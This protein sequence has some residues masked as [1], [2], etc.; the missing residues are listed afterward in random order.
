MSHN[1]VFDRRFLTSATT[2]GLFLLVPASHGVAS[3]PSSAPGPAVGAQFD[4]AHVYVA[5]P[6][7]AAFV[8]SFVATF[9]GQASGAATTHVT[10]APS[11][12]T[13]VGVETP[14]GRL[15]VFAFSTPV[16]YPF[17]AEP[18]GYL[19]SDMDS[20]VAGA[21][22]AGADV[23][24]APFSDPIGRDAVIQWP[25]GVTMQ[26]YWH[27]VAPSAPPLATV[28][29]HRVYVSP[30]R[31]DTF[32]ADFLRFSKGAVVSDTAQAPGAEIGRPGETFRRVRLASDFGRMTVL[33]TDGHLPFPYGRETY[34]YEV[35]NLGETLGRA[36]ASGAAVLVA[37]FASD[38][39]EAAMVRFPGGYVAEIHANLAR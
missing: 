3:D 4:G 15:S 26:L 6:D 24:V 1:A 17:G 27:T 36:R 37:P 2:L 35:G 25:G 20:A 39:R 34:G 22:A 30:L 12:T 13:F 21:T 10:P 11:R 18:V 14:V 23:L 19:V 32:V 29:E 8:T 16:P 38:G 7:L 31:A 5:A 9:G 33:V 28:P